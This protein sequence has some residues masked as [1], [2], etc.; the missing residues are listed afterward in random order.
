MDIYLIKDMFRIDG[1]TGGVVEGGFSTDFVK[2]SERLELNSAKNQFVSFQIVVDPGDKNV[3]EISFEFD[4]LSGGGEIPKENFEVYIEWFHRQGERLIPDLLVPF[5]NPKF[6]A[7]I[8]LDA[9]YLCDQRAGVLWADLFIPKDARPGFYEGAL[10]VNADGFNK[11]FMVAVTVYDAEVREGS[12][13]TADFNNY[14][15]SFSPYFDSLKNNPNRYADGSYAAIE[16]EFHKLA[17]E[18]R[19]LF[20]NLPYRHSSATP[21]CYRPEL[22][23]EGK[24]MK[25]K[26][27]E[28]FDSHFGPLLDG[29]AFAGSR[30][31]EKPVEFMYLPFN[32]NWPASFEKWGRKGYKTEYRRIIWEYIRHFEEKG[33]DRTYFEIFLN[34]KKDYRFFPYT[35]DEIWY[36]HDQ[37]VVREFYDVI[38]DTYEHSFVKFCCRID[39]SNYFH[40][41]YKNDFSDIH[42]LW[43]AGYDMFNWLPECVD[44]M[45]NKGCILWVYGGV[46]HPLEETLLSVGMFAINCVMTGAD[47]FCAWNTTDFKGDFLRMPNN[48]GATLLYY[49]GSYFGVEKPLPSLRL[50]FLRNTMQTAEL[51]LAFNGTK[52][53]KE[54]DAIINRHFGQAGNECWWNEKP[55]FIGTPPR[56]WDFDKGGGFDKFS[57]E[58]KHIGRSPVLI[59]RI[60]DDILGLYGAEG[61]SNEV[62]DFKYQ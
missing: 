39:S 46:L 15:D 48:R 32:L 29:S 53:K 19:G 38:K 57:L 30:V 12:T 11:T 45:K 23:G 5:V 58:P 8:P 28:L 50:K 31:S 54:V 41:H 36:E 34:H 26:S 43:I 44:Y 13:I 27:W 42:K 33:W 17:R 25:V 62:A 55:E 24:Y 3:D 56:Y 16:R 52:Q 22:T 60:N 20:H 9:D 40:E 49:P 14:A 21:A 61:K 51:A 18:H 47:G 2:Y 7:K 59:E 4:G 10:S 1:K 6:A 35:V 37:D